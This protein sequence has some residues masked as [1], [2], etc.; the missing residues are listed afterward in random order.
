MIHWIRAI[1]AFLRPLPR[2]NDQGPAKP[3]LWLVAVVAMASV[4]FLAAAAYALWPRTTPAKEFAYVFDPGVSW[5]SAMRGFTYEQWE[6]HKF[7]LLLL[8][9]GTWLAG[10]L[11]A[12]WWHPS[13]RSVLAFLARGRVWAIALSALLVLATL[14]AVLRG[15]AIVDD[16]LAYSMQ[17]SFFL[18]HRLFGPAIGFLPLD[19]F[20]VMGWHGHW[21]AKYLPGEALLQMLS[22]PLGVPALAHVLCVPV[23][24]LALGDWV[25]RQYGKL[26]ASAAV[27]SLAV[28]PMWVL[29]SATGLSNCGAFTSAV[30]AGWLFQRARDAKR[31]LLPAFGGAMAL[32]YCFASRP[33]VAVPVG[34]VLVGWVLVGLLRKRD[35]WAIAALI[36]GGVM[37]LA[38]TLYYNWKL[39]GSPWRLPWYL[40]CGPE[41]YGFGR[42]WASRR[43]EHDL[44]GAMFN[45]LVVAIRTNG[46]WLGWP[47]S[48]GVIYLYKQAGNRFAD[49]GVFG[50]IGL[51][52]I[53]FQAGYYSPGVSDTGPVYHF[54]LLLPL[55]VMFGLTV[56]RWL[57]HSAHWV[58]FVAM[59]LLLGTGSF[60][61]EHLARLHRLESLAHDDW[62]PA[63]QSLKARGR[64]VLLFTEG[65]G[66]EKRSVGWL[67]EH[68]LPERNRRASDPVTVYRRP[69]PPYV[70]LLRKYYSDRD[71][72]Y[73]RRSPQTAFPQVF[74]CDERPDLLYRQPLPGHSPKPKPLETTPTSWDLFML[75]LPEGGAMQE[76]NR[77]H[78]PSCCILERAK[79]VGDDD[80]TTATCDR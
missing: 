77:G 71:C 6:S 50:A 4:G 48:L 3:N 13:R 2:V 72:F 65:R 28:S 16:E 10:V 33:Q 11:L 49:L 25:R 9:P 61:L 67:I 79:V 24:L 66:G 78:Y 17:A 46:F 1:G 29:T 51:A 20:N 57:Q 31:G 14:I 32:G 70:D 35:R 53:V 64:K 23:A 36:V 37:G 59:Q 54:E 27:I 21:T 55:S 34:L 7:R 80:V 58:P 56:R 74:A 38:P 68:P 42:I 39:S 76:Q 19:K 63:L 45:L 12:R 75:P 73:M 8:A 40:V 30:V 69:S 26:A 44:Y 43:A 41:L 60:Y 47:V 15:R 5:Y 18:D 52:V 62:Q 22:V